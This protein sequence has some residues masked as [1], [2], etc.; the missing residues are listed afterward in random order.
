MLLYFLYLYNFYNR[1]F[2]WHLLHDTSFPTGGDSVLELALEWR[3]RRRKRQQNNNKME[4]GV[5]L[6]LEVGSVIAFKCKAFVFLLFVM[7]SRHALLFAALV[8][9]CKGLLKWLKH[10]ADKKN[11]TAPYLQ[12]GLYGLFTYANV[13]PVHDFIEFSFKVALSVWCVFLGTDA[14]TAELILWRVS[15]NSLFTGKKNTALRA[16]EWATRCHFMDY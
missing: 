7:L 5:G 12:S 2:F 15:N 14:N 4:N 10:A 13:D 16:F 11:C 9:R 8:F 1:T 3:G 6:T